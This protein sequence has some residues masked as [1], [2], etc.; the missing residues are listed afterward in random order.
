MLL[1]SSEAKKRADKKYRTKKLHDGTKKQLNVTLNT[2]DF[3]MID[4]FCKS[5]E[6]SKPSFITGACRYVIENQIPV[7]EL[8]NNKNP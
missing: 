2:E 7:S 1:S 4:D 6:I 5:M 3:N 8:K